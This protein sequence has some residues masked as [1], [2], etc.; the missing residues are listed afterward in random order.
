MV[1]VYYYIWY[2]HI[3]EQLASCM[4]VHTSVHLPILT[5]PAHEQCMHMQC[6][7]TKA[8]CLELKKPQHSFCLWCE[9]A[10]LGRWTQS[11]VTLCCSTMWCMSPCNI[12]CTYGI[13]HNPPTQQ[14]PTPTVHL[15]AHTQTQTHIGTYKHTC[16][17][18]HTYVHTHAVHYKWI[19]QLTHTV[20]IGPHYTQA[21]AHADIQS[22]PYSKTKYTNEKKTAAQPIKVKGQ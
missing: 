11:K 4:H 6:A 13:H 14:H 5:W 12:V 2:Q 1:H 19:P 17:A 3:Y 16:V 20:Y 9:Q 15:T 7:V 8:T 22:M 21:H 10:V 18:A